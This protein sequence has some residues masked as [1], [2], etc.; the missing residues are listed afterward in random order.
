[1]SNSGIDNVHSVPVYLVTGQPYK[2]IMYVFGA[3]VKHFEHS[4]FGT[5]VLQV[6]RRS[7]CSDEN[8]VFVIGFP[9]YPSSNNGVAHV[10]EHV[11]LCGSQ[12][13]PVRDPFFKML[14]RSL[15]TYMNPWTFPDMTLYPFSTMNLQ[16]S[17]S[18]SFFY[19]ISFLV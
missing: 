15:A 8:R 7:S 14:N 11:V 10:L 12:K 2:G 4:K 3:K 13:Y 1:M 6:C 9:T 17:S 5:E 16:L 19:M 18:V